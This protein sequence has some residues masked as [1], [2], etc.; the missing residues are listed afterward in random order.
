MAD[1]TLSLAMNPYDRKLIINSPVKP[2]GRTLDCRGAP[3]GGNRVS[4]LEI[5]HNEEPLAGT[6]CVRVERTIP[7]GPRA[8]RTRDPKVDGETC[9]MR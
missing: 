1:I 3:G 2:D 6:V 9:P 7:L 5:M 4:P 8:L